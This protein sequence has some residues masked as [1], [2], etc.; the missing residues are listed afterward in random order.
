MSPTRSTAAPR[1]RAVPVL[2]LVVLLAG[3]L[4]SGCARVRT[5]LAV[6]P[7]DTVTGEIII[8]T[9]ETGPDDP[10]PVVTLPPELRADV[11]ITPYR[12]D[13]Y[14]GSL[15]RFST[16]TFDQ[17]AALGGPSGPL[18]EKVRLTLRRSGGRVL[19]D[20]N[21]DLTTASADR[22]DFQLK[23][24][25]PGQVLESDGDLDSGTVSW[26][27]TPGEVGDVS[28]VV[29]YD[30]PNAPSPVNWTLGL[31]GL[32]AVAAL[33]VVLV[34]RRTRNPPLTPRAPSRRPAMRRLR[35]RRR[36]RAAARRGPAATPAQPSPWSG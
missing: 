10:G 17:V 27:F 2:L 22:A 21:A 4:L 20:G 14:A 1:A 28:A 31:G 9:P 12:Q 18:G 26:N 24:S 7:D 16:L 25:F 3:I 8:A 29:A 35:M 32:V 34:A 5:A 13:G 15:L 23:I 36:R 33:G 19:F 30:D 6:Q 11:D